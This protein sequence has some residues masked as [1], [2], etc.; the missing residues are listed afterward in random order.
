LRYGSGGSVEFALALGRPL[1]VEPGGTTLAI[2]TLLGLGGTP[3]ALLG[4]FCVFVCLRR[5]LRRAL[6]FALGLV[7]FLRRGDGMGL[8][9]LA[10][11]GDLTA[12]ALAFA[13]ALT[14]GL[15]QSPGRKEDQRDHD[16]GGDNDGDYGT[17]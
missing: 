14:P 12:K 16:Y 1:V 6:A 7:L 15:G 8:G 5:M 9:L 2:R 13:F 3:F 11:S 17:R 10:M 4:R